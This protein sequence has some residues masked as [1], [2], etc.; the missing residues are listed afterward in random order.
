VNSPE[1]FINPNQ[2]KRWRAGSRV[3]HRR[4][5]VPKGSPSRNCDALN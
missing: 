2:V 3:A 5:K 1:A 4:Q